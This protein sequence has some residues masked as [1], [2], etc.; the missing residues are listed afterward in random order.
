MNILKQL[1]NLAFISYEE[2]LKTSNGILQF[3]SF[4]WLTDNGI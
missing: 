3:L 2:L 1:L 4:D